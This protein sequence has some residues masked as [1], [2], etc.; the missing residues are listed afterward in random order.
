MSNSNDCFMW[1]LC[2]F[3]MSTI[4]NPPKS[5]SVKGRVLSSGAHSAAFWLS[6][7]CVCQ[8]QRACQ[9]AISPGQ[10]VISKHKN[11]RYYSSKVTQITSQM[12]YEVMF[13]DGSFSNDTYPEDIVV[14]M[15]LVAGPLE[16]VTSQPGEVTPDIKTFPLLSGTASPPPWEH[17]LVCKYSMHESLLKAKEKNKPRIYTTRF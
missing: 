3:L 7:C 16:K 12:F 2:N 5:D 14:R 11:L 10:T 8:K 6:A 15:R 4:M 17:V 1:Q 9:A 13:D